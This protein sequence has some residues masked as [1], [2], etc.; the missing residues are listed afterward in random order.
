MGFCIL[1]SGC[2]VLWATRALSL[3][4]SSLEQCKKKVF[5]FI[6]HI[7]FFFGKNFSIYIVHGISLFY[8]TKCVS[9]KMC[10]LEVAWLF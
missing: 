5:E 10:L 3:S 9:F 1:G 4:L 8:S 2:L 7:N 6:I